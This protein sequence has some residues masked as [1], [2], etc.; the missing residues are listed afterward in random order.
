MIKDEGQGQ[1]MNYEGRGQTIM[2]RGQTI[3]HEGQGQ[4]KKQ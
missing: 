3:N 1:T 2:E 4:M